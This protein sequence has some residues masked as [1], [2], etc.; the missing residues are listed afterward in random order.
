MK[1]RGSAKRERSLTGS[2][3][4]T[5]VKSAENLMPQTEEGNPPPTEPLTGPTNARE[6]SRVRKLDATTV[7]VVAKSLDEM[8]TDIRTPTGTTRDEVALRIIGQVASNLVRPSLRS[9]DES[10][11]SAIS[12]MSEMS[13][14][15]LVE[16]ML[17]SQMI[18]THEAAMWSM[19]LA[20][21]EEQTFEGREANVLRATRL[22]RVFN[23]QIE[24]MQKLKGTSCQQKVTVGRQL[25]APWKRPRA[26]RGVGGNDYFEAITP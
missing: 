21:Q 8:L 12:S 2:R 5:K 17:A 9:M 22:M 20:T 10:L 1:E 4:I 23:E 26:A 14:Q 11:L 7:N 18:A 19:S 24:A 16:A 15:N 6:R 3:P 13:P 25:W